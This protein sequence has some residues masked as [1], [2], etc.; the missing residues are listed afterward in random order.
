[1][2]T[3]HICNTMNEVKSASVMLKGS[4]EVELQAFI[5]SAIQEGEM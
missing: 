1:M 2:L 4:V 3:K 5:I